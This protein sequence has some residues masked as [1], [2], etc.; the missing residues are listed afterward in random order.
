MA[1]L[2]EKIMNELRKARAAAT[3]TDAKFDWDDSHMKAECRSGNFDGRPDDF[4][5]GRVRIYHSTWIIGRLDRVIAW[6]EGK[7]KP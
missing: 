7:T 3:L 1:K 2:P 4:I 6:A 5:K